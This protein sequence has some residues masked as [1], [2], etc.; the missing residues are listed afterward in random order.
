MRTRIII[1]AIIGIAAALGIVYFL[2]CYAAR[3]VEE[4]RNEWREAMT[5]RGAL[6]Y[7]VILLE[8]HLPLSWD[9][10]VAAGLASS[11]EESTHGVYIKDNDHPRFGHSGDEI[12]DI[13]K[14]KICFGTRPEDI[15]LTDPEVLGPDGKP[16]RLMEFTGRTRLGD[17]FYQ[18]TTLELA[19]YMK[20]YAKVV[21]SSPATA[22]T[23]Q[24]VH[25]KIKLGR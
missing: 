4:H 1:I 24:Q 8:G 25:N 15:T 19:F 12:K 16:I 22:P 18:K 7:Y 20:K 5:L 11:I 10:L 14:F 21:A 17:E 9:D 2:S 23:M 3:R 6:R 13:R